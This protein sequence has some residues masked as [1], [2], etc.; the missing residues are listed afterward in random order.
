[1]F[2]ISKARFPRVSISR[3][4]PTFSHL[5]LLSFISMLPAPAFAYLDPGTGSILLQGLLA[6]VAGAAMVIKLYWQR[7]TGL[8]SSLFGQSTK[9]NNDEPGNN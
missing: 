7:I 1:M 2:D 5:A 8:F 9:T 3:K 4:R 6:G